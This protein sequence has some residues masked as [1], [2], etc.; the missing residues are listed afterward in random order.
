M[1][2]CDRLECVAAQL[3]DCVSQN[4]AAVKLDPY[5]NVDSGRMNPWEKGEIYVLGASG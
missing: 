2:G 5:L 4:V 1:D 3:P